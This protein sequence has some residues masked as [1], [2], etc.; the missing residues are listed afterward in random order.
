ME[1]GNVRAREELAQGTVEYA[2]VLLALLAIAV[3]LAALWHAGERGV[4]AQLAVDAA[5]HALDASG[6]VDIALY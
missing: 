2:I 1:A 5:S 6:A 3:G 4:F